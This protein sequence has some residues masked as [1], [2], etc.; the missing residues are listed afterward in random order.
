MHK[1]S[2]KFK[3]SH[4]IL[5]RITF[6]CSICTVKKLAKDFSLKEDGRLQILNIHTRK[7]K[8]NGKLSDDVD[9]AEFAQITKV[10]HQRRVVGKL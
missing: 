5:F 3:P 8:S 9:L 1:K 4:L 7:M 6:Y 2:K 10:R